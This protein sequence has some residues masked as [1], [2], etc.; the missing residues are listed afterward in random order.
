MLKA[1]A[2]VKA[3]SAV[4]W[5]FNGLLDY[6][7]SADPVSPVVLPDPGGGEGERPGAGAGHFGLKPHFVLRFLLPASRGAP[8]GSLCRKSG[9]FRELEGRLVLPGERAHPDPAGRG[10]RLE[11]GD[12]RRR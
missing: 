3:T 8:A 6:Q 5:V 10:V 12:G 11:A 1:E 4:A 9:V 2:P 7:V